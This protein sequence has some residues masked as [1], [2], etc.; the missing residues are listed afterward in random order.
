MTGIED[1]F[2]ID[3]GVTDADLDK[4][5]KMAEKANKRFDKL[6][7]EREKLTKIFEKLE[8]EERKKHAKT[9]TA[10]TKISD[11]IW[12]RMSRA[13][14]TTQT[15]T[16]QAWDAEDRRLERAKATQQAREQKAKEKAE[17]DQEKARVREEKRLAREELKKIRAQE[18]QDAKFERR[19]KA[20]IRR[21]ANAAKRERE[22]TTF[23][24]IFSG[25][26]S[27]VPHKALGFYH[28]PLR[29]LQSMLHL[30]PLLGGVLAAHQ[31]VEFIW[32]EFVKLDKFMKAFRDRAETRVREDRDRYLDA[33]IAA[34][35]AQRIVS[36]SYGSIDPRTA[37][38]TYEE[39]H[40]NRQELEN[41]FKVRDTSGV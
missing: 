18:R 40:T 12:L 37:Y 24:R 36:T 14:H 26:I 23:Q 19:I 30:I 2:N 8:A 35:L 27:S 11:R 5:D 21:D 10:L 3:L 29:T 1:W 17:R 15:R 6:E 22:R 28:S 41:R 7:K 20:I 31:I 9:Q 13:E 38:N 4:L 16:Q 33:Q 32:R 39:F 34:G 25:G